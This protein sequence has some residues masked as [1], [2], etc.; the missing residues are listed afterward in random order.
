[1]LKVTL[2]KNG[3]IYFGEISL[4][5]VNPSSIIDGFKSSQQISYIIT[6]EHN[7]ELNQTSLKW[8]RLNN[9][10][11]QQKTLLKECIVMPKISTCKEKPIRHSYHGELCLNTVIM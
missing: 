1:M 4:F 7:P 8:T 5:L 2:S 9:K 3:A 11:Q 10:A 6:I